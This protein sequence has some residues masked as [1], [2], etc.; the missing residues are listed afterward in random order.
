MLG[1]RPYDVVDCPSLGDCMRELN[2]RY[3]RSDETVPVT[4]TT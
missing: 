3:G 1:R 4:Q 2:L